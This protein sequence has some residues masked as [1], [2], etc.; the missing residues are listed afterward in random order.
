MNE[1]VEPTPRKRLTKAQKALLLAQQDD[2]CGNCGTS[3]IWSVVDG[4]KVYGPMIDEHI[5]PLFVGGGNNIENRGMWCVPCSSDK[6]KGEAGPNA[7]IRRIIARADGT[8]KERK[9]IPSRGFQPGKR[10]LVSRPFPKR[11]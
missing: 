5:L 11:P 7:K 1:R 8:R 4:V 2:C 10:K 6:T 3:L 9:P